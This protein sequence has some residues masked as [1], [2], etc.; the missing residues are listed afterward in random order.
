MHVVPEREDEERG[1]RYFKKFSELP[2][3][4]HIATAF[5]L[6]YLSRLITMVRPKI[7]L[8]YGA[9]IG[10]IT[11]LLLDHPFRPDLIVSTEDN[12]FC[13]NALQEN[14]GPPSERWR[15]VKNIDS[16]ITLNKEYDIVIFD[17][18]LGDSRQYSMFRENVVCFVESDRRETRE[19][20]EI[21]LRGRGLTCPFVN[22]RP[23]PRRRLGWSKRRPFMPKIKLKSQKGCNIGRVM[24]LNTIE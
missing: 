22:Y 18:V 5:A 12:D 2:G 16:L 13:L 1:K 9:G 6:S 8:E 11:K 4:Q 24:S 21:Y 3:S 19:N 15:I 23:P 7:V 17:G 20:L 14:V 10:T